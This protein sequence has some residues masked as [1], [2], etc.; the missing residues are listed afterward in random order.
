[1]R[2]NRQWHER[3]SRGGTGLRVDFEEGIVWSGRRSGGCWLRRGRSFLV[4]REGVEGCTSRIK[5]LGVFGV[6]KIGY[7]FGL[8]LEQSIPV[9]VREPRMAAD[10]R[11][12]VRKLLVHVGSQSL[13]RVDR[14]QFVDQVDRLGR[15][16]L[17]NLVRPVDSPMKNVVKH[18][19][20]RGRIERRVPEKELKHNT[21]QGPPV[22]HLVLAESIDGLWRQIVRGPDKASIVVLGIEKRHQRRHHGLLGRRAI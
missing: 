11:P 18:L 6:F 3:S 12:S 13:A 22:T 2:R 1:M 7:E 16:Q 15:R 21:P 20:G 14:D 8:I 17:L 19:I 9:H 10:L 4:I 5:V